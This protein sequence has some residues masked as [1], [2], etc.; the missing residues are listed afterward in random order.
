MKQDEK[1]LLLKDFLPRLA[2]GVKMRQRWYDPD[3]MQNEETVSPNAIYTDDECLS[4]RG[5]SVPDYYFGGE[6]G[7]LEDVQ[8]CRIVLHP[9]NCLTQEITISGETFVPMKKLGDLCVGGFYEVARQIEMVPVHIWP[10][11]IIEKLNEWHINYRLPDHLFVP[12]T[13][14]LNPYK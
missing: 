1:Q 3:G 14:K 7:E 4:F 8:E 2:H 13:S 9:I 5:H 6:L 11:W 10:N 12:V